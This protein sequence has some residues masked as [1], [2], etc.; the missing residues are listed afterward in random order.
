MRYEPFIAIL[1][2]SICTVSVG[3]A[4]PPQYF[5]HAGGQFNA[6]DI[7]SNFDRPGTL[8]W[9]QPLA[10][11]HSTPTITGDRIF[12]TTYSAEDQKLATVALDRATG[13]V[14][15]ERFAKTDHVEEVHRV[16]SPAAATVATDGE[17]V[18]TFF[19]S[20]GLLCYDLYGNRVWSHPLG[21]FQ[22]EFGAAS[23][24]ILWNGTLF[25]NEDHDTN[26]YL[27]AFHAKTG[28]RQWQVPRNEFTR[29]YSTPVIFQQPGKSPEVVVAGALTLTSY[30]PASGERNWWINGLARI[31]NTTPA[32][33]DGT[34]YVATWSPGGDVGERIAMDAW[35]NAARELDKNR[36]QKITRDEL[37]PGPVLNRF[38]RIDIDQDQGLDQEEWEKHARVFE[39]AENAIVAIRPRNE[40]ELDE[41]SVLWR[42][43]KGIPYVASPLF[44]ED[45]IY[46]VKDGGI[47]TA[48]DARTGEA[49]KRGRLKGRG[50]YYASP[51]YADGKIYLA[52][53][54]GVITVVSASD[55][56]QILDSFDFGEMIYATPVVHQ[57][58][59]YV[60]TDAALYCFK[61]STN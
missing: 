38:F 25:L 44:H 5:R 51:I 42:Y 46:L 49:R 3:W 58:R 29:S 23:S 24:P 55:E 47:L 54:Q 45:V 16:S 2:S 50:N 40:G 37:S 14:L 28:K 61:S 10:I 12:L 31:V 43:S 19:G 20:Y 41:R 7:P 39:L 53:E 48:L 27:Y 6:V 9:R 30:D 18:Y 26:N 60:R 56:W 32:V 33:H 17:R 59:L 35:E 22:D 13:R 15:W 11:G 8:A 57:G 4:D 34:L 1:L 36:D 21:P 52:S